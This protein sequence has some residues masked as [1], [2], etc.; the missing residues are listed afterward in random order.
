MPVNDAFVTTPAQ[1]GH[2]ASPGCPPGRLVLLEAANHGAW[3]HGRGLP[4]AAMI[5]CVARLFRSFLSLALPSSLSPFSASTTTSTTTTS[6]TFTYY[7]PFL[8]P[9]S[10]L[11]ILSYLSFRLSARELLLVYTLRSSPRTHTTRLPVSSP[12]SAVFQK[13]RLATRSTGKP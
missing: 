6:T 4:L 9:L 13:S 1:P 11:F 10:F 3:S 12:G 8:L 2:P 5:L 7:F